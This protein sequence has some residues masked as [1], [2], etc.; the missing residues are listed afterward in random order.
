M[1]DP[2]ELLA[3]EVRPG[4]MSRSRRH[5]WRPRRVDSKAN[6]RLGLEEEHA[7]SKLPSE[8]DFESSF[9][10]MLFEQNFS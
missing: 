3:K 1:I 5:V 2:D 9:P 10:R 6:S 4:Q 7:G 8:R